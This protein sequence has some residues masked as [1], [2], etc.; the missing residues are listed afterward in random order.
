MA[1]FIASTSRRGA[2]RWLPRS[3]LPPS[4]F[5]RHPTSFPRL[6]WSWSVWT[7]SGSSALSMPLRL[8]AV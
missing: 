4:A 3:P 6:T 1:N 7:K 8:I 5:G 2:R